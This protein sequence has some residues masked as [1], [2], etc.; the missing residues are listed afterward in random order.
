M[1]INKGD[2]VKLSE[3]YKQRLISDGSIEHIEEFGNCVGIVEDTEYQDESTLEVNVRWQPSGL[4]FAYDIK[5]FK[6]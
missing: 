4:R 2:R 1:D 5:S 3:S 6:I